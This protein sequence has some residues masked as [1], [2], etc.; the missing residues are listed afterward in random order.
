M[1]VEFGGTHRSGTYRRTHTPSHQT[2]S[3]TSEGYNLHEY[4]SDHSDADQ[5]TP[6]KEWE[7]S[8]MPEES[9]PKVCNLPQDSTIDSQ[10]SVQA[11]QITDKETYMVQV[12][13]SGPPSQ[14]TNQLEE[15]NAVTGEDTTS[16][17]MSYY[18]STPPPEQSNS[19]L[20]KAPP[21]S[22]QP[23]SK[24][25]PQIPMPSTSVALYIQDSL[26][27]PPKAMPTHTPT[28]CHQQTG[29]KL[30]AQV[31]QEAVTTLVNTTINQPEIG[32]W[33]KDPQSQTAS[34]TT[35]PP[36]VSHR[37]ASI[38]PA[39]DSPTIHQS[40]SSKDHAHIQSPSR[41]PDPATT[42]PTSTQQSPP[43]P[44]DQSIH[45]PNQPHMASPHQLPTKLPR[46][47]IRDISDTMSPQ[48]VPP[49]QE[50]VAPH[51][52][53]PT[54][55]EDAAST[56]HQDA[57]PSPTGSAHISYTNITQH[58]SITAHSAAH[59][60]LTNKPPQSHLEAN[61]QQDY[62]S[63]TDSPSPLYSDHQEEPISQLLCNI[64]LEICIQINHP[65]TRSNS[66]SPPS[67]PIPTNPIP[68]KHTA[69]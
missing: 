63:D 34:Q 17:A 40:S 26:P 45:S 18:K 2:S 51:I 55:A 1:K 66:H 39:K 43:P 15:T 27:T 13:S 11:P 42:S 58:T 6:Q 68:T 8:A 12:F 16:P 4:A 32:R 23:K 49:P 25:L 56:H 29:N 33:R 31:I 3:P 20:A 41:S 5:N 53:V 69:M 30:T 24:Y 37:P 59:A 7:E 67:H 21:K 44:L 38:S 28:A 54:A 35:P 19:V 57:P 62:T 61:P 60:D 10:S 46:K 22:L 48:P 50:P 9:R 14:P 64:I 36:V 52:H 47:V 65:S